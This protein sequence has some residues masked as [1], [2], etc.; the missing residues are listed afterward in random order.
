MPFTTKDKDNDKSPENCAKDQ[1]GK[2]GGWWYNACSHIRLNHEFNKHG[3]DRLN[4]L[5]STEMKIRP[6]TCKI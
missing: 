6:I 1:V 2:A 3:L 4:S 5:S